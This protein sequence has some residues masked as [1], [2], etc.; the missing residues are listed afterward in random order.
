LAFSNG[1]NLM[2]RVQR[3]LCA[4]L[5][6]GLLGG[7]GGSGSGSRPPNKQD[8]RSRVEY[9]RDTQGSTVT[10]HGKIKMETVREV[11]GKVQYQTDDGR[12]W[13]VEMTRQ[14]D[15]TY[16]YGTPEEVK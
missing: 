11:D 9:F 12:T 4:Y 2:K 13:R 15:G 6:A 16:R 10:P 5:I 7:C 1:G 3:L 8:A 14:A